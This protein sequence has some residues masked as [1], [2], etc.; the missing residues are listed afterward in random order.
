MQSEAIKV[1][2]IVVTW[3]R[4]DDV[5]RNIGYLSKSRLCGFEILVVENGSTDGSAERLEA[6][7]SIR[8]IRL[9]TNVGPA[10]ARNAA[11]A[12]ARGEYLVFLDSDALLS[13][14][15][16]ARLVERMDRE[17]TLGIIG[18][19]IVN[20]YSRRLDQWIYPFPP[21]T[22]EHLDF[23]TYSF[24]AAGAIVRA[25]AIRSVGGFWD[26]LN[27]Y[28]EEVDL[29]IRM[30]R[31]GYRILYEP[32]VAVFH[33][34]SNQGRLGSDAFWRFQIRNWIWIFYRYYPPVERWRM[35]S[36]YVLLYLAKGVAT[37]RLAACVT[38]IVEGLRAVDV[39]SRFRDK[40]SP[41]EV[42]LLRTLNRRTTLRL[43]R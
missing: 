35:I 17:P 34:V 11:V 22:H 8:L 33:C 40:L 6:L 36:L 37:R 26:D 31:A 30:I 1:S 2:F 5:L 27:I 28:N 29:S 43:G 16:A 38:G 39:I 41:R 12:C 23:E 24:S 32:R 7:D 42:H 13:K 10:A 15:G 4:L 25:E 3:N 18:C 14:K 20:A 19:R 21:S 9:D